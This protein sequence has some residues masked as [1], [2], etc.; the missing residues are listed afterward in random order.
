MVVAG[1]EVAVVGIHQLVSAWHST[2]H[3]TARSLLPDFPL[4]SR[5]ILRSVFEGQR[6]MR[7]DDVTISRYYSVFSIQ[8]QTTVRLLISK[9]YN[10]LVSNHRQ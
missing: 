6:M 5:E 9:V 10:T 1:W 3:C 8:T 4:G 2:P 7:E